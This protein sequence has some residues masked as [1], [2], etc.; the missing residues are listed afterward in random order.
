MSDQWFYRMFGEDFGP[1]PFEKLREMADKGTVGADDEVRSESSHRWVTAGSV[2]GLGLSSQS[3]GAAVATKGDSDTTIDVPTTQAGLDDWYCTLHDKELGP[4]S[5]EELVKFARH[6]NL[7]ADDEV[8]LGA[9]GKWRRVGSIG[10][11]VAVLPYRAAESKTPVPATKS[12]PAHRSKTPAAEQPIVERRDNST[13]AS[14]ATVEPVVQIDVQ[15]TY[16]AAYEQ[17]RTQIAESMMAQAEAAFKAAEELAKAELAW[18]F[19]PNINPDW[20]GWM[21]GVEFG[22][23]GFMQVFAL[24]KNDQLKPSDFVRN[25]PTGQYFPSSSAPGLFS[26]VATVNKAAETLKLAK[27]QAQAA[28]ALTSPPPLVPPQVSSKPATAVTTPTTNN[29]TQTKTTPHENLGRTQPADA[30]VSK[31]L[32]TE[33]TPEMSVRTESPRRPIDSDAEPSAVEVKRVKPVVAPVESRSAHVPSPTSGGHSSTMSSST[34]ASA[35]RPASAPVRP[36]PRPSPS[37]GSSSSF[38]SDSIGFLKDPKTLGAVGALTVL[39]LFIGWG[40]FPGNSAADLKQF[41]ELKQVYDNIKEHRSGNS[42]DYT[43]VMKEA[44]KVS[45]T[46][47]AALVKK[48]SRDNPVKLSLLWAARDQLPNVIKELKHAPALS[49]KAEEHFASR[50]WETANQLGLKDTGLPAPTPAPELAENR[51]RPDGSRDD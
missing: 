21:G 23:V 10:R 36:A 11:L 38:L 8:K 19:A 46:I 16:Q 22:P 5:F 32:V 9:N 29:A 31:R 4:L 50:L 44:D 35:S 30:V 49:S 43:A 34:S 20:W 12:K 17:A 26:A 28:A 51:A 33:S 14:V 13:P 27:V 24:A 18:A 1:V 39:L 41:R 7:S 47:T 40:Y 42:K 3:G 48:A 2:D 6:D 15:A 45:K 37:R 25:G